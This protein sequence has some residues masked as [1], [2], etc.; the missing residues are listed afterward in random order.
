MSKF[1]DFPALFHIGFYH[2]KY[3]HYKDVY[4]DNCYFN[5]FSQYILNLKNGDINAI[6]YF[7]NIL[8]N[9]MEDEEI[10]I[11]TVPPHRAGESSGIQKLASCLVQDNKKYIDAIRCLER[12]KTVPKSSQNLGSRN[13]HAHLDSIRMSNSSS[14]E[15]KNVILLDD[16]ITTG[17][18]TNACRKIISKRGAKEVKIVCLGK[19]IRQVEYA[20]RLVEEKFQEELQI[21]DFE[22]HTK[23]EEIEMIFD[24]ERSNIEQDD[25][26]RWLEE[27]YNLESSMR[28]DLDNISDCIGFV[29]NNLCEYAEEAH[30]AL[31]GEDYLTPISPFL[32]AFTDLE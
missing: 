12:F 28:C 5:E 16:V 1:K 31:D 22:H 17:S 11:V 19:T 15:D 25:E 6:I 29:E 32:K 4:E 10:A 7:K 14:I 26:D 24:F 21:L 27:I 8:S 30:K 3:N 13:E 2:P 18:S 9:L 23:T 20:H